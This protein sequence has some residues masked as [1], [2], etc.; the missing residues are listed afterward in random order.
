[1]KTFL[2]VIAIDPKIILIFF[3][4]LN[5]SNKMK[6][7]RVESREDRREEKRVNRIYVYNLYVKK[8]KK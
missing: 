1:M 2:C 6:K 3:P 5:G 7:K 8:C 4:I